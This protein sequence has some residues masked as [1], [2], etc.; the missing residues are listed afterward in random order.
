[1]LPSNDLAQWR[2][3]V[4]LTLLP[5]VLALGVIAAIP[6]VTL[7][8]YQGRWP[9]ALMD[10]LALAWLVA[11]WRCTRLSYT[12][13][14][15]NFLAMLYLVALG[16]MLAVGP[17]SLNY[18]MAPPAMAVILLGN[19][20]ALCALA[21]CAACIVLL[22]AN[23]YAQLYVPGLEDNA[24]VSSLVVA[25]NFT[26]VGALITFTSGTLL[27]GIANSLAES[28]AAT[29]ELEAGQAR[30]RDV[31][32]E[33][34]LTSEAVARLNDMV[35]IARMVD[36]PGAEQPI[37]FANDAFLRHTGYTREQV[38]G[39]SM[40]M[41][42][43]PDTDQATVAR[44]LASVVRKEAVSTE[45]LLY[46][47]R[48][49]PYWVEAEMVPFAGDLGAITHWV[50]VSRDITERRNAA[51]AI[52]RLA[53]YDVL[54]GLPNRRLLM[55]RLERMVC[56]AQDSLTLGAV[57]YVDLDNF[58]TV[59]DARGHGVGD[60]LLCI[61]AERL[62]AVVEARGS[63]ARLGGDEF[64]VLLDDLG[65][66]T[67]VATAHAL[68]VAERIRAALA[69]RMLVEDQ[70]YYATT[71]IGVALTARLPSVESVHD[72]LREAD[73]AMYHAK[74]RGRNGVVMFEPGMLRDAERRL[75][76]ERDLGLALENQELEMHL[77]LQVDASQQPCGAEL[78]M[79]WRRKDGSS[80]PPDHFI[81][82]AESS[83]LIVPLGEWALRQAC[84]AWHALD[85]IGR[86]LPL[87]VNVS[88]MQ[89]RQPEFV[90]RV[91]AIL[92]ETGVPPGQLIFEVTEGL[93]VGRLDQTVDR[94]HALAALG[95]RIS[96]DDFG[97][98]YSS[99]A[100]L[101]RMPLYELKIDKAF[102]RDTPHDKGGT[103]I[104]QSVLAMAGH[105][106]LR[107]VAEGVETQAQAEYLANQGNACM[108]GYLF[109]R[110]MPLEDLLDHLRVDA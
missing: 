12:A 27:K 30:L 11:I 7:V 100:Y 49:E 91:E 93:L 41:L 110:P 50:V 8:L 59:N 33:L 46:T 51:D 15:L 9:V 87:S 79:R 105:L 23:G 32:A 62:V 66:D 20:A 29:G 55:D 101:T 21:L 6:S 75:T 68:A 14:V 84:L 18:L 107:V 97:T 26:C 70:R 56:A 98:G 64:V 34:R 54:T 74:A 44:V 109:H 36:L 65:L 19:R 31:N 52:H 53:F 63:V 35:L 102:I 94:M 95:I 17:V 83:G 72:L 96:V 106:G 10:V 16:L 103:A 81:P 38:I 90:T 47:S 39:R 4:F 45:L 99:L 24:L 57:L 28:R 104:V 80:V 77:Q 61:A 92:A 2:A 37:I 42:E 43:G 25:L 85:A 60:Q 13:R 5:I 86:A 82:V 69:D 108:Q 22:G 3:R 73:T 78:L 76:L 67:C 89:F 88:P 71:S 40:R 1:M 48:A 58:K